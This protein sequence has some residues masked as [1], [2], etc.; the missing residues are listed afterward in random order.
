VGI[1]GAEAN[2]RC[3]R[4]T[5]STP[6][7][8][9]RPGASSRLHVPKRRY[10]TNIPGREVVGKVRC[11]RFRLCRRSFDL[12]PRPTTCVEVEEA[13]IDRAAADHTA[14]PSVRTASLHVQFALIVPDSQPGLQAV[15]GQV[16]TLNHTLAHYHLLVPKGPLPVSYFH[17]PL[18]LGPQGWSCPL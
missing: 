16:S 5:K 4:E 1:S 12:C 10:L 3:P 14:H 18:R 13:A 11:W 17:V 6:K 15:S 8:S 2:C 9:Y 7:T